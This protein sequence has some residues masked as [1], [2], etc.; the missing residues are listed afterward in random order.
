VADRLAVLA[1]AKMELRS[2]CY[3]AQ[4]GGSIPVVW[5]RQARG[6]SAGFVE[7]HD[8]D[9]T[10]SRQVRR[11]LDRQIAQEGPSDASHLIRMI[12]GRSLAGYAK[13]AHRRVRVEQYRRLLM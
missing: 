8:S 11:S 1:A 2:C 4:S 3:S 10:K 6:T 7:S 9:E 5:L 12:E 13:E